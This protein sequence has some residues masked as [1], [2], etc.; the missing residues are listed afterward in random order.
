MNRSSTRHGLLLV[1]ATAACCILRLSAIAQTT[2]SLEPSEGDFHHCFFQNNSFVGGIGMPISHELSTAGINSRLYYNINEKIC[3]GPEFSLFR[4]NETSVWDVD[5]VIHYIFETPLVG[6]YPVAGLNY[7]EHSET[8][9]KTALGPLFGLG[10]HRNLKKTTLFAEYTRVENT[11]PDQFIT[12]G[13]L[14]MLR[15]SN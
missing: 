3:F 1:G 2:D 6:I 7:T 10:I 9:T 11:L 13:V 15:Q 8:E 5:V 4:K 12:I 14:Y